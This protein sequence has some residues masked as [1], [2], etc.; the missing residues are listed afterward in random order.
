MKCKE[1][2]CRC[3]KSMNSRRKFILIIVSILMTITLVWG[4]QIEK[5]SHIQISM[6]ALIGSAIIYVSVYFFLSMIFF[7]FDRIKIKKK[8]E[9]KMPIWQMYII[10]FLLLMGFY[11]FQ[12]M[13][14]YPGLFVF[15]ADWQ[16]KMYKGTET[17]TEHHPVLHTLLIGFVIDTIYQLTDRFNWG[18]AVYTVAQFTICAMCLSYMLLYG[19]KKTKSVFL[20]VISIIFLGLYPP[21]A[22]HVMSTTKDAFFLAFMIL[23]LVLSLELIEDVRAFTEKVWK[24]VLWCVAVVLM[25]IFRNNCF[26][27]VPFLLIGIWMVLKTRKGYFIGMMMGVLVLFGFYKCI[28]VPGTI[29]GEVDGREMLSVPIQQL[30]RIYYEEDSDISAEEKKVIEMLFGERGLGRYHPK[31]ADFPKVELDM[32]YYKE[33]CAEINSMYLDLVKRNIKIA[34]ESFLENTCGFW[35]PDS[36]LVQSDNQDGYWQFNNLYLCESNS[37]IPKVY[38]FYQQFGSLAYGQDNLFKIIVY[39][40]AT[41]FYLFVVCFAYAI[42]RKRYGYVVIFSFVLVL[43]LTYLLG[44]VALVRYVAFLFAMAPLY[45]SMFCDSKAFPEEIGNSEIS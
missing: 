35:Y 2:I 34:V 1:E 33:N 22:L 13:V 31:I 18:V 26:Y 25:V 5:T 4:Y 43:W 14:F 8:I 6:L 19:L 20:T 23:S 38:E 16:Y 24:I 27:A 45:G 44:P 17:F 40:P 9:W 39:S 11:V 21:M 42:D 41:Y 7:L 15:D 3:R 37:K 28:V 10:I 29:V 36:E 32:E 12:F 30:V